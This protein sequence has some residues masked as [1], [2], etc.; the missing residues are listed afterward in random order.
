M[1]HCHSSLTPGVIHRH[2]RQVLAG[3]LDWQPFRHSVSVPHLLDLLLLMAATASSL[4]ATAR[5][6]FPVS[7]ETARRAVRA[8]LPN[9]DRLT[10]GL[11][12]ALH[13][14]IALSRRDRRRPWRLA[15][16]THHKPYYGGRTAV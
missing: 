12:G 1:R 8:N 5:R 11:V 14:A 9:Q 10:A 4:F 3:C 13:D 15:I 6:F 16:D 7:H 2:A